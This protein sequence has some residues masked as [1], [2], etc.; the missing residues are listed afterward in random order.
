[1]F[2]MPWEAIKL[3]AVDKVLPLKVIPAN[4]LSQFAFLFAGQQRERL[5]F[6]KI[7]V[8]V[9]HDLR[10][11]TLGFD[12]CRTFAC[13]FFPGVRINCRHINSSR[14]LSHHSMIIQILTLL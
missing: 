1:M 8:Q 5:Y 11:F 7:K 14:K 10:S 2:G 6:L 9:G 13:R 3:S 12:N 4:I